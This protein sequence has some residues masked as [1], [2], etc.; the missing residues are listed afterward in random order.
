MHSRMERHLILW[1]FVVAAAILVFAGWESYRNTTRFAE[2]SDWQKHTYEVLRT[3]DE[4]VARLVDAETGQRGYLLTGNEAYLEPYREA[5]KNLDQAARHLKDL[6]S[7]NPNQ[8]KR[9]QA[10]EPLTE[11]KLAELQRTIDLRR[12][13]GIAAANQVV[14]EGSGKRWMDQIRALASEMANEENDLLRLRTQKVDESMARSGRTIA[15]GTLVSI[16]LLVLC[17]GLSRELSER[18]RTRRLLGQSDCSRIAR[19]ERT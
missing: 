3:L 7:D 16:S 6:T 12:K 2:A 18:K 11:K 15:A 13:E 19:W 14:L 10:L 17:F 5:I 8:Q 4:T 9:I 1:G